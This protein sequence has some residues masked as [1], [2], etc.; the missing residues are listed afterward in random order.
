MVFDPVRKTGWRRRDSEQ[1]GLEFRD[2][3]LGFAERRKSIGRTLPIGMV[4]EHGESMGV[5]LFGHN[6][7]SERLEV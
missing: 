6:V 4:I 1:N 5:A 3:L 7:D 2:Y